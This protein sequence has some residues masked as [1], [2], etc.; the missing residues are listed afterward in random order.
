MSLCR[1]ALR[2]SALKAIAG[3]TLV[4]ANV[5]D[6]DFSAL[7]FTPDGMIETNQDKPFILIY[8][9][10]S[11]ASDADIRSLRANGDLDFVIEYG[12]A[13]PMT[14]TNEHG[15]STIIGFGVPATDANFEAALDMMDRQVMAILSGDAG[16][17]EI[18]RGLSDNVVKIERQRRASADD[19]MRIAARQTRIT[20]AAKPDPVPGQELAAASIW[21][22][23]RAAVTDPSVAALVDAMVSGARDDWK[24]IITGRGATAGEAA[25]YG[26]VPDGQIEGFEIVSATD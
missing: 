12:I 1:L 14:E 23:F 6:S 10:D 22:R 19:G 25:A 3:K 18:W 11:R 9:D 5:T 21:V 20:L 26:I 24:A 13:S 4:G 17:A 8:T 16:W 7:D 15:E 2:H